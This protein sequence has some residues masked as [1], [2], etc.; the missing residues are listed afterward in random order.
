VKRQGGREVPTHT[1]KQGETIASI[2]EDYSLADWRRI[3][4]HPNNLEFRQKRPN[5]DLIYPGDEIFVPEREL[6]VHSAS[7]DQRHKF[8][9]H[10]PKQWLQIL[11]RDYNN[12]PLANTPYELKVGA[13]RYKGETGA[14]GL[15][16]EEI[17]VTS[18]TGRLVVGDLVFDLSIGHLNPLN[19]TEDQG[20]S[21]M[22]GRLRNLGYPVGPVNGVM[23]PETIR[24]IRFFQADERLPVTGELDRASRAKLVKVH[25]G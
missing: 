24:A 4:D 13:R 9:L 16:Q 20:V 5:P 17:E 14:D 6:R 10:R 19:Q 23:G 8:V 22:Q 3:Y 2:A 11:V 12:K 7:T 21:G 25:G 18:S 15:L 1:V